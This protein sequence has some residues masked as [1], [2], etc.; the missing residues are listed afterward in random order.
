M[1]TVN[2]THTPHPQ[3]TPSARRVDQVRTLSPRR[4]IYDGQDRIGDVLERNGTFIAHDRRGE[5]V[6]T[7]SSLPAAANACWRF[8]H[9][10]TVDVA[11]P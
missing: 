1:S 8:A 11:A 4:A 6:G 5:V 7:F 2:T 10:Q 3:V 9:G